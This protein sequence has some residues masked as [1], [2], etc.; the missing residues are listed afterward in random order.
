M[1]LTASSKHVLKIHK[2]KMGLTASQKYLNSLL[3][4]A[5][6]QVKI[7][8]NNNLAYLFFK[9]Q[10]FLVVFWT[11]ANLHWPILNDHDLPCL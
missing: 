10:V 9:I 5:K 2:M 6:L 4:I 7:D 3:F 11:L 1:L 8:I